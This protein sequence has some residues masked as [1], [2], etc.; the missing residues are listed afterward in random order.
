[1]HVVQSLQASR[2]VLGVTWDV[3]SMVMMFQL[4][5]LSCLCCAYYV[6]SYKA[7]W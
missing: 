5:I 3:T 2:A 4:V 1:M 6:I 7:V